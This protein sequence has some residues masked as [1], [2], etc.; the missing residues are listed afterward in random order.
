LLSSKL[1]SKA[2]LYN[3][4]IHEQTADGARPPTII[5]QPLLAC[6]WRMILALFSFGE[7]FQRLL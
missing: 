1:Q 7:G 6:A 2:D 3:S 5:A 4:V